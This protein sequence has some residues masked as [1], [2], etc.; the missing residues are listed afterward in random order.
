MVALMGG[1]P[2]VCYLLGAVAF[3]RFSLSEA[4]HARI[5]RELDARSAGTLGQPG[6]I[7]S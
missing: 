5:R 6:V 4:E 2:L 1:A 7:A 3:A